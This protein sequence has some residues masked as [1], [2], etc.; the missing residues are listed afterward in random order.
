MAVSKLETVNCF[1]CDSHHKDIEVNEYKGQQPSPFTHW[2]VCPKTKDT[3]S[4]TIST[5]KSQPVAV[6]QLMVNALVEAQQ[7]SRGYI[8]LTAVPLP[9]ATDGK[10]MV[11]V[12]RT[13]DLFPHSH[14]PEAIKMI[15]ENL[16]AEIGPP[17]GKEMVAAPLPDSEEPLARLFGP[18]R[19]NSDG[20]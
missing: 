11:R 15:T 2:F 12:D 14:F 20:K 10:I 18:L 8:F 5:F 19:V 3:V 4:L 13:S 17:Q 7:S 6:N 1:S 9:D 16:N